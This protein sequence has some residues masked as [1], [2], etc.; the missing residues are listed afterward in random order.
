LGFLGEVGGGWD[1]GGDCGGDFH[2]DDIKVLKTLLVWSR[3]C[4]Y[5]LNGS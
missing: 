5:G 4:E 1:W 2:G 3:D